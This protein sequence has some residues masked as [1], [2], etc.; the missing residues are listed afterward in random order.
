MH[1]YSVSRFDLLSQ[2]VAEML[3]QSGCESIML[4]VESGSERIQKL[5]GKKID[6]EKAR[7]ITKTL[8]KNKVLVTNTYMMGHP[9]ETLDELKLTLQ[10][11]KKIPADQNLLQIYRPFPGTPYFNIFM[12]RHDVNIPT[13][14]EDYSTFGVLGYHA[15]ISKIPTKKLYKEFYR[16]NMIE[17]SKHLVNLQRYY[18]RNGMYKQFFDGFKNNR[19]TYKLKEFV[20]AK[21]N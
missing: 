16:I 11:M 2:E 18:W 5:L 8:R 21:K 9:D 14:L 19:F 13:K 7:N 3:P 17:Q 12:S 20:S 4:G 6:L 15:N 10:F 1:W